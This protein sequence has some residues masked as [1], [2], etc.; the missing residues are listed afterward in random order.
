MELAVEQPQGQNV[1]VQP[2]GFA[3]FDI[4]KMERDEGAAIES[5]RET[6]G[7]PFPD[8]PI[9]VPEELQKNVAI[10]SIDALLNWG[11]KNA[12]WPVTFGLACC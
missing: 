5:L 9:H 8:Q 4:T 10:S 11:R 12:M 7:Q 2:P 3:A 6:C 1:S